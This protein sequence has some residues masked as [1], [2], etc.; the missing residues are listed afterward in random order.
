VQ[1]LLAIFFHNARPG[2][3]KR[4]SEVVKEEKVKEEKVKD[5]R[6]GDESSEAPSHAQ[7]VTHSSALAACELFA[8]FSS[9]LCLP[10]VVMDRVLDLLM[11]GASTPLHTDGSVVVQHAQPTQSIDQEVFRTMIRDTY[12]GQSNT[13]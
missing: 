9:T 11:I 12:G 10:A 8:S 4:E 13:G 5:A 6:N 7:V 2:V 3:A 1:V